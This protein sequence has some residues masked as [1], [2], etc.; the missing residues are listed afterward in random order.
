MRGEPERE[1]RQPEAFAFVAAAE[2]EELLPAQT[3]LLGERADVPGD[4]LL[5]EHLVARRAPVCAW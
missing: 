4:E 5:V 3:G 2:R 1:R